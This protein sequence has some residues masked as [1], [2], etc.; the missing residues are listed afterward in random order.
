MLGREKEPGWTCSTTWQIPAA[1][2]KKD[3]MV[4]TRLTTCF[5]MERSTSAKVSRSPMPP[6]PSTLRKRRRTLEMRSARST[7]TKATLV[8]R[9]RMGDSTGST[10]M[11]S[12]MELL[13]MAN[14]A[15]SCAAKSLSR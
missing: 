14:S 7:R 2:N 4:S 3:A 1:T 13:L 8:G 9:L 15:L 6:D 11:T 5:L 12:M 10:V